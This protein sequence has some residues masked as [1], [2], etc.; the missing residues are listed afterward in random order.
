MF[1]PAFILIIWIWI[2]PP[3]FLFSAPH[4]GLCLSLS[5]LLLCLHAPDLLTSFSLL[6][7]RLVSTTIGISSESIFL[8]HACLCL[9]STCDINAE[10]GESTVGLQCHEY[11]WKHTS[12]AAS[13]TLFNVVSWVH[14][15]LCRESLYCTPT[16]WLRKSCI[17][18]NIL[19][20]FS[21]CFCLFVFLKVSLLEVSLPHLKSLPPCLEQPH[22]VVLI[23]S[24]DGYS[25]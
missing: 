9:L 7:K 16:A 14:F 25:P 23:S 1:N 13:A 4:P 15:Y 20:L 22:P 21:I 11:K 5:S 24:K 3:P 8:F 12:A 6:R 10:I 19:I 2:F 18:E 17:G